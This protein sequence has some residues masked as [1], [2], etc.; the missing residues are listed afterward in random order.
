MMKTTKITCGL[1]LGLAV[2]GARGDSFRTDLNPALLYY[3]AFLMAPK[4]MSDA[5]W[6]Y[7]SSKAGREQKLPQRFGPL[8]AGYDSEFT[9]VRE[10]V[11][12]KPP[13]D[14]GIDLGPGPGTLLPHLAFVKGVA[15]A[16]QPRAI[17][18]LQHENQAD[19]RDDLLAAFVLGRNA[20]RDGTLIGTL[21]QLASEATVYATV[22]GNFGRF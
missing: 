13:C 18:D 4:T 1:L 6:D 11:R 5:D 7:L 3:R 8:L 20:A 2:L 15:V 10:A 19:A 9:L 22:A 21:V 14:W 17:W 16:A 12:Q